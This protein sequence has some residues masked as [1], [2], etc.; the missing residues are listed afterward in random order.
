M[1]TLRSRLLGTTTIAA[2]A[3]SVVCGQPAYA[4]PTGGQVQAGTATI[5]QPAP[6]VTQIDQ[7]TNKAVIDWRSFSIGPGELTR[8]NQPNSGSITLNRVT[9]G[10]PSIILGTLTANG[11]V[12]LINRNGIVFGKS[13][14]VDVAGLVAT[15][16]DLSNADFMAGR[17][18]FS[19]N[20]VPGAMVSNAGQITIR[21]AGLAAL[22]A[23][24]VE[25]SGIIQAH[26]GRITL[27]G[28]SAFTLD[29]YGDGKL[30]FLA[31][32]RV[33]DGLRE[34]GSDH[35]TVLMTANAARGVVDEAINL[36]G[37]AEAARARS[38]AG[39][40]VLEGPA[41]GTV[42]NS[43]TIDA[44]APQGQGG[45]VELTGAN[46][47]LVSGTNIDASG[48][49]G[50][51]TV[52][53]GGDEHGQGLLPN[54]QSV[55]VDQDANIN[56]DAT[57]SGNGGKAVVWS[58]AN[59]AFAGTIS[60]RGG[61]QS[62]DGGF[63]E[64]SSKGLLNFTGS[65]DLRALA[66]SQGSLLLD[67]EN[68][69][70]V[71][72]GGDTPTLP[73][74]G[75]T[76][77]NPAGDDSKLSVTTLQNALAL[78]NVIVT[79]GSTGTQAGD[80]TVAAS[81]S[82]SNGSALTLSANRNVI[83]ND[84]VTIKNTGSGN[85]NLRADNT[86]SGV[87]TV[88]FNGTGKIDYSGSTGMVSIY[89]NPA[90]NPAGS[91]VN[92]SSYASVFDYAPFVATNSS[93]TH[94]LTSYM[95]IN[96]VED[97]QNV[98]NNLSANFALGRDIDAA[99]TANWNGGAGFQPLSQTFQGGFAGEFDGLGHKINGLTINDATDR[100]VGL[101]GNI[102]ASA[103]VHSMTLQNVSI[104][105]SAPPN[106]P[107]NGLGALAGSSYGL[108]KDI[109]VTGAISALEKN[110]RTGSIVSFN[111]GTMD[112]VT[113][114][115][116]V[117]VSNGGGFG[118]AGGLV[119]DNSGTISHSKS[120]GDVSGSDLQEAG[121]L[122][123]ANQGTIEQSFAT[124]NVTTSGGTIDTGG[125]VGVN[126]LSVKD[127]Y[128]T[129]SVKAAAGEVGGA[130]GRTQPTGITNG[131]PG[132]VSGLYSVGLVSGPTGT[133]GGLV[134]V[135]ISGSNISAAYWDTQ[136]SGQAASS[137]GTGL[138]TAQLKGGLPSGF[139]PA[140]W[141]V[142][143]AVN[144][145]YPSLKWQIAST[146]LQA[147]ATVV[148]F[149]TAAPPPAPQPPLLP[150]PAPPPAPNTGSPGLPQATRPQVPKPAPPS[151]PAIAPWMRITS[152]NLRDALAQ[153]LNSLPPELKNY[154]LKE[155][156]GTA[157]GNA[158]NF[159]L[160]NSNLTMQDLTDFV[161]GYVQSAGY[162]NGINRLAAGEL[163]GSVGLDILTDIGG[164][165][166]YYVAKR[167][168]A[169]DWSA[170][171]DKQLT[172]S[173]ATGL[174]ATPAAQAEKAVVD[175]VES[176]AFLTIDKVKNFNQQMSQFAQI[177]D[178]ADAL[179]SQALANG[180]RAAYERLL[181]VS[182]GAR[183]AIADLYR[184]HPVIATLDEIPA[185]IRGFVPH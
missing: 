23:P 57:G 9:G 41:T 175:I 2:Y 156:S 80:I 114:S 33:T 120:S 12:W 174:I 10:D 11:Q 93:V 66:G 38:A 112:F 62:G 90:S 153:A 51:G 69:S 84:G 76:T 157:A 31:P 101:F 102:S 124:S 48:A 152:E 182:A 178:Q 30:S 173:I 108:L 60:A 96:S 50:G 20:S 25:N 47:H 133:T 43:G 131:T 128:A 52:L 148:A 142:D 103:I 140:I 58:D 35:G 92:M 15:T 163:A 64:V 39:T 176:V 172:A 111:F 138:T 59:T 54:A 46:V 146:P 32:G 8:F 116:S 161:S 167:N 42:T 151:V 36:T 34:N 87:G 56:I 74:S 113:S 149:G 159:V 17:Y 169:S 70:I 137:S 83:V 143:P 136:S 135:T 168:G 123:A 29:F 82:W 6:G 179:A 164:E 155:L 139:D 14:R 110:T 107:F 49:S 72:S 91:S 129:G 171:F 79:T 78:G 94:Q 117:T 27:A 184:H 89:Y 134:G 77:F 98:R 63:S 183:N 154:I 180:D 1:P 166:A 68:V 162:R 147:T 106:G 125:L 119:G 73:A 19:G 160:N 28:A 100:Y 177:A 158:L 105:A 109:V 126:F 13:A 181:R 40:I 144:N 141:A 127:S 170:E 130:F 121:G 45:T 99:A 165:L 85:L 21:D 3:A 150:P 71:S 22:V 5:S 7:Q 86:G 37:Y 95:L 118:S 24:G 132:V 44:S 16:L 88:T 18:H 75:D 81:L 65:V 104:K 185:T 97:L 53:V 55:A 26:Y 122:A 61:S 145:G 115:A 67:P 4:A